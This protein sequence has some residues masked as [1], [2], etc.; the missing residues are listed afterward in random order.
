MCVF[1]CS[2]AVNGT[3]VCLSRDNYTEEVHEHD[4][5]KVHNKVIGHTEGWVRGCRHAPGPKGSVTSSATLAGII[6]IYIYICSYSERPPLSRQAL[7]TTPHSRTRTT[8]GHEDTR[9]PRHLDTRTPGYQA[10]GLADTRA[11]GHETP[12]YQAPGQ[13]ETR[14]QDTQDT[15]TPGSAHQGTGTPGSAHQHFDDTRV[16]GYHDTRHQ[17]T[18]TP[19]YHD[20]RTKQLYALRV[21]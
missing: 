20:T 18:R 9:T 5:A 10:P 4:C 3:D 14:R 11:P 8:P 19:R 7:G 15:W 1:N 6:H 2:S 13:A 12:G 16:P 21:S 17:D